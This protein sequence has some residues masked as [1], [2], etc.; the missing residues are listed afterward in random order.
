MY[1]GDNIF[2]SKKQEVYYSFN[3]FVSKVLDKNRTQNNKDLLLIYISMKHEEIHKVKYCIQ[4]EI[5]KR[6]YQTIGLALSDSC[7][8]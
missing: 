4:T 7:L 1:N 6:L 3:T 5:Q 8:Q 2:L